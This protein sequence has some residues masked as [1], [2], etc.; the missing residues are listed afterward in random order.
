MLMILVPA[1]K[2][3]EL[4][5]ERT[6]EFVYLPPQREQ[7]LKL[8][9]SLVSI[10]KWES[11]WHKPFLTKQEKTK[12]E[13]RD[14]IRCMTLTPNVDESVYSRLTKKNF[15]DV[16]EYIK[17]PMTA[18]NVPDRKNGKVNRET[19]TSELIYYWMISEGIPVEFERWHINRLMTLIKMCTYKNQSPTKRN[20]KDVAREY[21]ALN[22]ARRKANHSRG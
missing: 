20:R 3:K 22:E 17:D 12:D 16:Y 4:W 8:E 1:S 15:N 13:V 7:V 14:Y 10:S 5:D 6:Q 2:E 11:K 18:S 21:A 9:H 19:P